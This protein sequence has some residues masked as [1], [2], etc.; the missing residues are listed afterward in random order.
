[1][2]VGIGA[3]G[4]RA[5][6]L[7][8]RQ[9]LPTVLS[10][11]LLAWLVVVAAR[12]VLLALEPFALPG[13]EASR[14]NY[15][16]TQMWV[17]GALI[18]LSCLAAAL[19][20]RRLQAAATLPVTF[21][22]GGVL[23][24]AGAVGTGS[25][26]SLLLVLVLFALAWL[27]GETLLLR[28]L[29]TGAGPLVRLPIATGLGL[30]LFGLLLLLLAT[31]SALNTATVVGGAG[32]V[33]LASLLLGR[34]QLGQ[35]LSQLRTWRPRSPTWLET[36][37]VGMTVGIVAYATLVAFVPEVHSD[38]VR[39]HLPLAREIW[40]AGAA[41]VFES[42]WGSRSPVQAHLLYAVAYGLGDM[43][44]AKL[45]H[46]A[47]G[48]LAILGVAG[49]AWLGSGGRDGDH[50]STP[51]LAATIGAAIFATMPLVLW[52]LGTAYVDLFPAFFAV[53]SVLAIMC[54]QRDGQ[55]GWLMVA[56]ALAGFGF[57][58]KP[59]MGLVIA[60][61]V[62]ALALVGR[63][64]WRWRERL[65]SLVAF[66]L[67]GLVFLPWIVRN[68]AM[69]ATGSGVVQ[70]VLVGQSSLIGQASNPNDY[71]TGRSLMSLLRIPWDLA[72]NGARFSEAGAGDIGVL[73]LLLLPLVI[74]A[75]RTRAVAFI[76]VTVV[77]SFLA[78][79]LITQATRHALPVLALAAA[80]AGI[81]AARAIVGTTFGA[82][83]LPGLA[84][85]G[86]LVLGL[87]AA[88]FLLIPGGKFWFPSDFLTS[89]QTKSE[90]IAEKVRAASAFAAADALLPPDT[91]IAYFGLQ[92]EGM[93]LY[94]EA[95]LVYFGAGQHYALMG[96]TA[97]EVLASFDRLGVDYF[98]WSR[99]E[100]QSK[101]WRSTVLS[102]DF[103]RGHT[104]ILDGDRGG[105]LFE[106]LPD[107]GEG[108]G[109]PDQNLLADPGFESLALQSGSPWTTTGRVK[110]HKGVA[111]LLKWDSTLGQ[112]APAVGGSPYLLT[113][114]GK[115]PDP[116]DY[117]TLALRWFDSRDIELGVDTTR[118]FPGS[119]G[120][121][122][123]LWQKAPARA[124]S[125]SAELTGVR[126]CEFDKVALYKSS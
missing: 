72:F 13:Q 120:S 125:V 48:M 109:E 30:G 112:R 116:D 75:P 94:T 10:V 45:V 102:T 34:V 39:Q 114:S 82:R 21:T 15:A 99:P 64:P 118:V 66:G 1:L 61:V 126:N 23:L 67:G 77:I 44:A 16:T 121:E 62:V 18:T 12:S 78:W 11:A 4:R 38:A 5:A 108:W 89:R 115:C 119:E 17:S 31:L 73:L 8:M 9:A 68:Y 58:A 19:L 113:A 104:R 60:A 100:T 51:R 71:G 83:R 92:F 28:L 110:A 91:P 63:G 37:V 95:R 86:G 79:A 6:S 54:W 33:L 14:P 69:S 59:T 88:P 41:P 105:Y 53:A 57:A 97:D 106:I 111:T 32:I 42:L 55:L 117:A 101:E 85:A 47:V 93:Q 26:G 76:A 80:L 7:T 70:G 123:F 81:G 103:L 24:L 40:Q 3:T 65:L 29:G 43:T 46:T 90:L 22:V 2:T 25:L 36:I 74:F 122:Q 84:A 56:G 96:E 50:A 20:T 49:I 27:L 98:I 87:V 107:A 35:D 124:S 52:E